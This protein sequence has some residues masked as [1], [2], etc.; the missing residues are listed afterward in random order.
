[1]SE[2]STK[3]I[4][5]LKVLASIFVITMPALFV[6]DRALGV[7]FECQ[8]EVWTNDAA[9]MANIA[10]VSTDMLVFPS[11]ENMA[12][13]KVFNPNFTPLCKKRARRIGKIKGHMVDC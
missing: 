4:L 11:L 1:M 7:F 3:S 8:R 2:S 10:P 12:S 13:P 6:N 9:A 5:N